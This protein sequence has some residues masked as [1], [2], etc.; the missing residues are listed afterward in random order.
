[1]LMKQQPTMFT[2]LSLT[3]FTAGIG[4]FFGAYLVTL[5]VPQSPPVIDTPVST[6]NVNLIET[7]S[8]KLETTTKQ[9][10][11]L[12]DNCQSLA[13]DGQKLIVDFKQFQETWVAKLQLIENKLQAINVTN[14]QTIIPVSP[15]PNEQLVQYQTLTHQVDYK[16]VQEALQNMHSENV[17]TRQRALRALILLGSPEV[18]LQIGQVILDEEE[19]TALRRDLIQSMDWQG[20]S[21][22]LSNLFENSKNPIIRAATI[23]AVDNSHL[24]E[25][26]KQS[27]EASLVK[28]FSNESDD[29]IKIATLNYFSNQN[30]SHL[31]TLIDNLDQQTI[32]PKLQEHIKFL[33][34][35]AQ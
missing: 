1:M 9:F 8:T 30:S 23:S 29:L 11:E 14:S 16:G 22:Q 10:A 32:S 34:T 18:K 15:V 6:T 33:T 13:T 26:E 25:T 2:V 19:D 20:S 28:N 24:S 3:F 21:E 4:G 35:P 7:I 12:Q 27:F 5:S 31:Y 17:N